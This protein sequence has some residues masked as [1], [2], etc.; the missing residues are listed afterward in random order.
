[1]KVFTKAQKENAR[2]RLHYSIRVGRTKKPTSCS[3][4]GNIVSPRRIHGHHTNYSNALKVKWLCSECH[5]V[6]HRG[7][8]RKSSKKR[9]RRKFERIFRPLRENQKNIYFDGENHRVPVLQEGPFER[10]GL[11]IESII[12]RHK[13]F[14]WIIPWHTYFKELTYRECEVVKLYYGFD[15]E[16]SYTLEEIGR[17]FKVTRSRAQQVRD[18]GVQ[19]LRKLIA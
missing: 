4:C 17:I 13:Y 5:G 9:K 16:Y 8:Y 2:S 10:A 14:D 6:A 7:S 12:D 3:E 1:M 11:L 15:S 18:A 19:K